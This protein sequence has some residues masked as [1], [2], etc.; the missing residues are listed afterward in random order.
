[1]HQLGPTYAHR[2]AQAARARGLV[3]GG[4]GCVVAGPPG[5]V[6]ARALS[7]REPRALM[8]S[9]PPACRSRPPASC[10]GLVGRVAALCRYT[11]Q[12]PCPLGH[13]T[14]FFFVL[15]YN[16]QPNWPSSCNTMNYIAIQF[17]SLTI[18]FGQ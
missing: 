14:I 17:P 2:H 7:A 16:P 18:Q 8:P 4:S 13:N 6:A 11:I 9:S 15:Q 3:V 1:M 5:C 12:Q 10:G